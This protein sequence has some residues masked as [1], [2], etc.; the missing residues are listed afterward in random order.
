MSTVPDPDAIRLGEIL[1]DA[2]WTVAVAE[3]LTVG[4]LQVLIGSVSGASKYFLGGIT[5]YTLEQKNVLLNVDYAHAASVDCVSPQ[6]ARE[7]AMGA[8]ALTGARVSAATT[9]FAEPPAP[10]KPPM[11]HCAVDIDGRVF[12]RTVEHPGL[13]RVEA[14]KATAKAALSL[15]IWGLEQP[16]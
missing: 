1:L 9:G 8:R 14:Q 7:M 12:L 10:G 13:D 4:R 2:G 6:V 5:T 3:S 11:A 15:L 16:R